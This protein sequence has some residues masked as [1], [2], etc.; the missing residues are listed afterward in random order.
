MTKQEI[1]DVDKLYAA[2]DVLKKNWGK[3]KCKEA[4][5][6]CIQCWVD[7]SITQLEGITAFMD[8]RKWKKYNEKPKKIRGD[9]KVV[10]EKEI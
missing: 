4:C 6:T 8:L 5:A 10:G 9:K 3:T 1:K 2:L 7:I